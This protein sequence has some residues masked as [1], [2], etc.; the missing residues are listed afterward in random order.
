MPPIK[1]KK[2]PSY[3]T[4]AAA[5][6]SQSQTQP[7]TKIGYEKSPKSSWTKVSYAS[8]KSNIKQ[9]RS[10]IQQQKLGRKVLFLQNKGQEKSETNQML[11]LNEALQQVAEETYIRF[12]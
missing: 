8:C 7:R 3:A 6:P 12:I 4:V 2:K 10:T 1:P 9:L 5:K 11:I